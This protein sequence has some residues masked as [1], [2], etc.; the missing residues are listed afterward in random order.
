LRD[1]SGSMN[2]NRALTLLVKA[3]SLEYASHKS[4]RSFFSKPS[5]SRDP[6]LS[7]V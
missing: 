2:R 4:P 5:I 1:K 3:G 7:A 6:I